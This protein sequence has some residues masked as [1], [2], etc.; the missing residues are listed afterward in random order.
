MNGSLRPSPSVVDI[1][2]KRGPAGLGFNIVGGVDQQYVVNDN[3]IYV[4]KIKE[5]GAAALD[6]R[7]QEGDKILAINGV[8][9]VDLMHKSA[10]DL[11]RM[12]GE[13]VELR[14]LKK[15]LQHDNGSTDPQPDQPSP[16]L[17]L[18]I[19]LALAGAAL[20]FSFVYTRHIRKHF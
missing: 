2:L 7:L 1:K 15:L 16:A 3:G 12:A 17:S 10:V 11:F 8:Q 9:L 20:L 4:A 13:D 19:L 18:G 5:D 14:V 6:G